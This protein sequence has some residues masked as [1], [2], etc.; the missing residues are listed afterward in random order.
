M[1]FTS[2]EFLF[3]F[4]PITVL[5]YYFIQSCPY[6]LGV[7]WLTLA[8]LFFY[9]WWKPGYIILLLVSI[10]WNFIA[11][12]LLVFLNPP[13]DI[14]WKRRLANT[15]ACIAILG[16]LLLLIYYKYFDFLFQN[17]FCETLCNKFN[18]LHWPH[19]HYYLFPV[20]LDI[21]LD[22]N[23]PGD[24]I[25]PLGISF[26]TFTQIAFIVDAYAGKVR[27]VDWLSYT[28]FVTYFPHLM[29]GP[30]IHHGEMIPQFTAKATNRWQNVTVGL[31][32]FF[33]GLFKKLA[34][35]DWV[36]GYAVPVFN[37]VDGGHL[38]GF[39]EAW[40]GAL[41]FTLQIYFDFS[42]YTDM[43]LGI[44]KCFGILLP[45]NFNSP[46]KALD[47]I[48]FWRR[49]HMTL[50]RFLKDYIY[51]PT[52]IGIT[53]Y[54]TVLGLPVER[55]G[56]KKWE[57][58]FTMVAIPMLF[59]MFLSGVWHGA[60]MTFIVW[61]I[62]HGCY[63]VV[64]RATRELGRQHGRLSAFFDSL[65]GKIFARIITLLAIII[66]WVIFKVA[67]LKSMILYLRC[68]MNFHSFALPD[69]WLESLPQWA[70]F[71]WLPF[72]HGVGKVWHELTP[73]WILFP[74]L[75][76]I[77]LCCPNSQE[78]FADDAPMIRSDDEPLP[79]KAWWNWNPGLLWSFI[80][81]ILI[82]FSILILLSPRYGV[83][84]FLY[85]R[86]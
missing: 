65:G 23:I 47:M 27:S 78:I 19:L 79:P 76:W 31:S 56:G 38:V 34:L 25:L 39:I 86:F 53:H 57:V 41:A 16:D 72:Q 11:G 74:I 28:L 29:S 45:I 59:T 61:G 9:A 69:V 17:K 7:V 71:S 81:A 55:H 46:Y 36:A 18:A 66:G 44:S 51:K 37:S 80:M 77:V 70:H 3:Y 35:A 83:I 15:V 75:W 58:F 43:A 8:S 84:P 67:T 42:G 52:A 20:H 10:F 48:D 24:I 60:G 40:G 12:R 54:R 22:A 30:I 1:Q 68:L 5:V 6:R 13:S 2:Y 82:T 49:W 85:F 26:F 33:M 21:I 50:S 63:L 32:F 4:F 62:L 73:I 64:N 14:T